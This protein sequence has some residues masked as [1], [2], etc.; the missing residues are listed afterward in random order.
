[1]NNTDNIGYYYLF[2][3]D[4]SIVP[5]QVHY[6]SEALPTTALILCRS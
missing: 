6:H 2:K 1:L 3:L 4:S 5:L